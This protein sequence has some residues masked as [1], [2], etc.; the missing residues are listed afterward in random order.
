M[1]KMIKYNWLGD[2]FSDSSGE[3]G[4][5]PTYSEKN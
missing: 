3:H 2:K 4:D 1:V 5:E